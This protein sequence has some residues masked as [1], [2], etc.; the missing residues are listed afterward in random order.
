MDLMKMQCIEIIDMNGYYVLHLTVR[1][2]PDNN[3]DY[4]DGMVGIQINGTVTESH[5][6]DEDGA[7]IID[8]LQTRVGLVEVNK[9]YGLD[10]IEKT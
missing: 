3:L 10:L 9:Y 4:I 5:L 6:R 2:A 7:I 8:K 1:T